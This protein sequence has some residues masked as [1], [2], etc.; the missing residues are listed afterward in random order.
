MISHKLKMLNLGLL[1]RGRGL[2]LLGK[3]EVLGPGPG[4]LGFGT[5]EARRYLRTTLVPLKSGFDEGGSDKVQPL[6]D[7][8]LVG[9]DQTLTPK[10][11][12]GEVGEPA[13]HDTTLLST[14]PS[15][16]LA[17]T[18]FFSDPS[19]ESTNLNM[20]D[21]VGGL[22]CSDLELASS[23]AGNEPLRTRVVHEQSSSPYTSIGQD[24][25]FYFQP[26]S[27][28]NLDSNIHSKEVVSLLELGKIELACDK[29]IWIISGYPEY[30]L[31]TGYVGMLIHKL[32]QHQ[33]RF[34]FGYHKNIL[35]MLLDRQF[36]SVN[37]CRSYN[38]RREI[39]ASLDCLVK[40]PDAFFNWT[41]FGIKTR[42]YLTSVLN[43]RPK[44]IAD[45]IIRNFLDHMTEESVPY[46]YNAA[47][48][49][50]TSKFSP[51][52][53]DE[54]GIQ[55]FEEAIDLKLPLSFEACREVMT[56]FMGLVGQENMQVQ[57]AARAMKIYRSAQ[58][59]VPMFSREG[60]HALL[61]LIDTATT[62]SN[63]T[64][65]FWDLV[66]VFNDM[67]RNN[68]VPSRSLYNVVLKAYAMLASDSIKT[69]PHHTHSTRYEVPTTGKKDSK[70]GPGPG[71]I[72]EEPW[73]LRQMKEILNHM[74]SH[75]V[76]P[77]SYTINAF[78]GYFVSWSFIKTPNGNLMLNSVYESLIKDNAIP[79][80]I[81]L[82]Y[83]VLFHGRR[84][85]LREMDQT[86]VKMAAFGIYPDAHVLNTLIHSH[87]EKNHP[88][89]AV[90]WFDNLTKPSEFASLHH[91]PVINPDET[92]CSTMV[93]VAAQ[94][95]DVA[96]MDSYW[97]LCCHLPNKPPS[98]TLPA[99]VYQRVISAYTKLIHLSSSSSYR[100]VING[101]DILWRIKLILQRF[102]RQDAHQIDVFVYNVVIK[103]FASYML[104]PEGR[105]DPIQSY[106]S[107]KEIYLYMLSESRVKPDLRTYVTMLNALADS[108]SQQQAPLRDLENESEI[109]MNDMAKLGLVPNSYVITTLLKMASNTGNVTRLNTVFEQFLNSADEPGF[110]HLPIHLVPVYN[111]FLSYRG[112]TNVSLYSDVVLDMLRRKAYPDSMTYRIWLK[113]LVR[114][115]A[116]LSNLWQVLDHMT[117]PN[118]ANNAPRIMIDTNFVQMIGDSFCK[119]GGLEAMRKAVDIVL[120]YLDKSVASPSLFAYL[121]FSTLSSRQQSVQLDFDPL[122]IASHWFDHLCNFP[123]KMIHPNLAREVVDTIESS[124][125][126]LKK[127][128]PDH[129]KFKSNL[130]SF[131]ST[132]S[133]I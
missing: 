90:K 123:A 46:A 115:R 3:S 96:R 4:K 129:D 98:T 130:K 12:S 57:V 84:G 112:H 110:G 111:A 133:I 35:L 32:L 22:S 15:K 113:A 73:H 25:F 53:Y 119:V 126:P 70:E 30:Q 107:V 117:I 38:L 66:E 80:R 103:A 48:L 68:L 69:K 42:V 23:V 127:F 97:Q 19:S 125:V 106:Q 33:G 47:V 128:W 52:L 94:L 40:N 41:D 75:G 27:S 100:N 77:D 51:K 39:V 43:F 67:L 64:L 65:L 60:Y 2:S 21:E 28:I 50:L 108:M 122:P 76:C 120:N 78:L 37:V 114:L 87:S 121:I 9:F 131:K 5:L 58:P 104:C 85:E 118:N 116:P 55:L 54:Q 91:I 6:Y 82:N 24:G 101:K 34:P 1:R 45:A 74:R 18:S 8:R 124:F 93:S 92:I 10:K 83:L 63:H 89:G 86:V 16:E 81:G 132:H 71:Q 61:R 95:G 59:L 62:H 99:P 102:Q 109:L 56:S 29:I 49:S 79:D 44:T 17:S 105:K 36:I 31:P 20:A 72:L 26:S 14:Q 88:Q 11:T 13:V 7:G